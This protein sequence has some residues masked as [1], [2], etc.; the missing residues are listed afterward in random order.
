MSPEK[1]GYMATL[2][3]AAPY[4]TVNSWKSFESFLFKN[5]GFIG[6]VDRECSEL[7]DN[8]REMLLN[9]KNVF[10]LKS[11]DCIFS[12]HVIHILSIISL[13]VSVRLICRM[14]LQSYNVF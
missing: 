7:G 13:K 10:Q 14:I 3:I 11:Y 4:W 1:S 6:F 12:A 2:K 8:Y 5:E 9:E